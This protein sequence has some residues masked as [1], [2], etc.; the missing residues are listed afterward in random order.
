MVPTGIQRLG[1]RVST[2]VDEVV[3]DAD[4]IMMLR[5]QQERMQG[6]FFPSIREYFR[7]SV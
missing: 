7:C 5:I 1:V 2:S 6:A 3:E 4:V